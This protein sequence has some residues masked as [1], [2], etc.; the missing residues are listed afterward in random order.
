MQNDVVAIISKPTSAA[1]TAATLL[2]RADITTITYYSSNLK[3]SSDYDVAV[4][5]TNDEIVIKDL[6][7]GNQKVLTTDLV[8]EVLNVLENGYYTPE[9][10]AMTASE[11]FDYKGFMN[12]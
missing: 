3:K 5:F 7:S 11:Y 9:E 10:E 4:I 6:L 8:T 1:I 12:D 2:R